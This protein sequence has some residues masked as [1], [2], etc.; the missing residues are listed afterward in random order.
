MNHK[1]TTDDAIVWT[2]AD[3]GAFSTSSPTLGYDAVRHNGTMFTNLPRTKVTLNANTYNSV[4]SDNIKTVQ[5]EAG[6]V[7][8]LIKY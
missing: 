3:H 7:Q 1:Y 5:P 2:L 6:S 8:Y 4:Y